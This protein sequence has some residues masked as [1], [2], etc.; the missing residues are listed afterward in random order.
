MYHIAFPHQHFFRLFA[1]LSQKRFAE[2]LL[3]ECLLNALIEVEWSH[4]RLSSREIC[5]CCRRPSRVLI[6]DDRGGMT[7]VETKTS[8]PRF[9][10]VVY[11]YRLSCEERLD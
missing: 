6:E 10:W 5:R 9:F 11:M 4:S 2:Q 7:I 3:F 8:D 1:Y